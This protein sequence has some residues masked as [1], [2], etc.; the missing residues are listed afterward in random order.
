MLHMPLLGQLPADG[1]LEA[2]SW[3]EPAPVTAAKVENRC[4]GCAWPQDGHATAP[5]SAALATSFSNSFP[6]SSH[7][8]S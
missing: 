1:Q 2:D 4:V 6:Q 3:E 8:Y 7:L 5:P